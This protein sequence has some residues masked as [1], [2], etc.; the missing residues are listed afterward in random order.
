[1]NVLKQIKSR[2]EKMTSEDVAAHL[3]HCATSTCEGCSL[4]FV[5]DHTCECSK[6]LKL[7]AADLL[8]GNCA[9]SDV[10]TWK[11]AILRTFLGGR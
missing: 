2:I 11:N 7:K 5:N 4:F 10:P 8:D 3:R 6:L 1:M 9:G